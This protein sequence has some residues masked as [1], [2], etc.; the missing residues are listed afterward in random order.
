MAGGA[1]ERFFLGNVPRGVGNS[2]RAVWTSLAA[3]IG[4]TQVT[5]VSTASPDVQ[6]W[7]TAKGT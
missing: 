3:E 4:R 1:G 7:G 2:I 5:R 6:V